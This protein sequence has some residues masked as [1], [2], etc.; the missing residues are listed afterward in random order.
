MD[1][2]HLG[3]WIAEHATASDDHDILL[4]G[5]CEAL[6]GAGIPIWRVS[7]M[8]PA[9]DPTLRGVSLNW[10]AGEGISFVANA[11]GADEESDW[12]LSPVYALVESGESFGRWRL[13]APGLAVDFPVL[14]ALG[15]QG[16]IDYV[17]HIVAFAPGTALRGVA[18]SFCTRAAAAAGRD[19]RIAR[20]VAADAGLDR[21]GGAVR[22]A[23][24]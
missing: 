4:T 5:F 23:L 20:P 22:R 8:A 3:R 18:V 10:H 24:T 13:D 9:L 17:L 1:L 2:T 7:V 16:G 12:L 19:D 14:K 6:A 11:H 21:A 15:A